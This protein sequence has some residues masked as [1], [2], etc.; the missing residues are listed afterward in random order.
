M[1]AIYATRIIAPFATDEIAYTRSKDGKTA[2]AIVKKPAPEM[3]LA[4]A[5]K[6]GSEI[7][8]VATGEKIGWRKTDGGAAIALPEKLANAKLPFALEIELK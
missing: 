5:P 6:D 4:V 8:E 1:R 7:V 2:F 3:K